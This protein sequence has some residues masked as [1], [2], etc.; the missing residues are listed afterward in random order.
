MEVE[1]NH[2][3]LLGGCKANNVIQRKGHYFTYAADNDQKTPELK[4]LYK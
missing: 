3:K 1:E 2:P 4:R